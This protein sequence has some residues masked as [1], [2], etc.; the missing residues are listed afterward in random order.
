MPNHPLVQQPPSLPEIAYRYLREEILSRRLDFG[1]LLRQEQIAD[2]LNMS[3]LPVR[4]AL[5]RLDVEGLITLRPRRGYVVSSLDREDIEDIFDTR[6]L[7]EE[8][9][10]F[11][12]TKRRTASDITEVSALMVSI[13]QLA[14][15]TP[16][17]S[18]AYGT[19]N[20]AFHDRLFV[21]SGRQQLC[22]TLAM[23]R[24]HVERYTRV[25]VSVAPNLEAAIAEHRA[26]FASFAEGN[27]KETARQCRAHCEQTCAR[28]LANLDE[29]VRPRA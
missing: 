1:A 26:I 21:T 13:E 16:V 7:L 10:G 29:Y 15:N 9:A 24:D 8:R 23:L 14:R 19:Q 5:M 27:A 28:L 25:S 3:R 22:R 2:D 11:L 18:A 20:Q 6:A 4:E 17:D 12:A